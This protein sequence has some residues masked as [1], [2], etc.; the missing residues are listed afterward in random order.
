MSKDYVEQVGEA[1]RV[2]G[3]RVSLDSIVYSFGM[4]TRPKASS[5]HSRC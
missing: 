4:V 2:A 3:S 5:S 1:Y